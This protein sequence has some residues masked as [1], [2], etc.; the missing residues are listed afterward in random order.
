MTVCLINS[1][2]LTSIQLLLAE[3]NPDDGLMADISREY[4]L[5]RPTFLRNAKALVEKYASG[6]TQNERKRKMSDEGI[7]KESKRDKKES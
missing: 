4:K 2:V 3:P 6:K 5:D 1:I 7:T